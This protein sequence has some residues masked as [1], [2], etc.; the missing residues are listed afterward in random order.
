MS[1][2][3]DWR[4][5]EKLLE[6]DIDIQADIAKKYPNELVRWSILRK[7]MGRFCPNARGILKLI[8]YMEIKNK[9][10][11]QCIIEQKWKMGVLSK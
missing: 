8:C 1:E 5:L 9:A 10:F 3:P 7:R 2:Y 4:I 11:K 6:S